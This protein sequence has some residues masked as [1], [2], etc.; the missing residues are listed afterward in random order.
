MGL[1]GPLTVFL[2][3]WAPAQSLLAAACV[4]ETP[5]LPI[6]PQPLPTLTWGQ[7]AATGLGRAGPSGKGPHTFSLD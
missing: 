6:A 3:P 5:S 7:R 1:S 4:S 2:S